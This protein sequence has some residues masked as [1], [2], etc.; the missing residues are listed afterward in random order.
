MNPARIAYLGPPGTYSEQAAYGHYPGAR[1]IA[2]PSVSRVVEAIESGLADGGVAAIENS[3]EG[4]VTDTIDVLV[5]GTDLKV[6]GEVLVRVEHCLMARAGSSLAEIH[7][8]YS[9]PQALAQCRGYI[10]GEL[11]RARVEP[12]HSTALAAAQAMSADGAAAIGTRRAAEIFGLEVLAE[13]IQDVALNMTR[14]VTIGRED[15][16]R[17]GD[18]KTS[19]AYSVEHRPGSL[20]RS[21]QAFA[22]RGVNLTKIESRPSRTELGTYI[23]LVDC[24]GHREDPTVAEALAAV[25]DQSSFFKLLGSYP[26][27]RSG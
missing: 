24:E 8:V 15:A 10:E 4:S 5:H 11:P 12:S 27:A 13:G 20:V 21:L 3:I 23:F 14:F 6:C 9:H 22:D 7:V 17:S 2:F 26:R 25:R 19:I 1:L 16:A 18:D